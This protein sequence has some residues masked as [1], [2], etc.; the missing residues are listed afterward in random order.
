MKLKPGLIVSCQAL[1]D[2]PLYGGDTM[3]KMAYAAYLGGAVGIRANGVHDINSI[4]K[5]IGHRL[6]IIGLIKKNYPDSEVY[7]TPTLKEVRALLASDCDVI[8]LD[9]TNRKRPENQKI[10]DLVAYIRS[11][12]QKAIMAD[13]A[14]YADVKLA[15]ELG[16]DYISS[17]MRSY[18][19]STKG[20]AIPDL[21]YLK[22]IMG[23]G[24]KADL[25]CEGG[26][27]DRP[28]LEKILALGY[29]YVVIGGAITRP[30]GI[31]QYYGAAFKKS[32]NQNE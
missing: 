23:L 9:L 25:V 24:L 8:A 13:T 27:K 14:D 22:R 5:K 17:T 19:S 12:S 4:A 7:I 31:T 3:A 30:L 1:P 20:L 6:P 26:I 10:E 29:R 15:D 21:P 32:G 18:T 28:T 11:H 2:E 16:F